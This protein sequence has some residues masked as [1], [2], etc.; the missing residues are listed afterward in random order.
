M[1]RYM[2]KR[3]LLKLWQ[4][5]RAANGYLAPMDQMPPADDAA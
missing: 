5:W 4:A 3:L 2:E 1:K